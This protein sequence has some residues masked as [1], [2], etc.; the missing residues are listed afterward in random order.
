[1]MQWEASCPASHVIH[2]GQEEVSATAEDTKYIQIFYRGSI[3]MHGHVKRRADSSL[4]GASI[5]NP[6]R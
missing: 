1:M 3:M 4:E 2:K 5:A 6:W